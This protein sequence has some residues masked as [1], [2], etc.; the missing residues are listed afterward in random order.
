L[1][2]KQK[3]VVPLLQETELFGILVLTQAVPISLNYEDTDLL[4]IVG[5][6]VAG[7]LAQ[8]RDSEHLAEA[9]QFQAYSRLT[10]FLMHDLKNLAAQQSLVVKNAAKHKRNPEFVDDAFVTIEH[11]VTRMNA[12]IA[13]LAERDRKYQRQ[14]VN[15]WEILNA[16]VKRS[17]DRQPKPRLSARQKDISVMAD[18]DRMFAVFQHL[19]RNAQDASDEDGEITVN[20]AVNNGN[21]LVRIADTGVGMEESFIRERLFRPFESTKGADGMGIGAYQAREYVRE[22]QGFMDVESEPGKGTIVTIGLPT[23]G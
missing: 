15:L 6:Q 3:L 16:V 9:K 7:A 14:R 8:Q 23:A 10:A 11:S 1:G 17:Q 22:M 18:K 13:Q 5:R 20:V 4:K 21:A 2:D 19:V 12:L